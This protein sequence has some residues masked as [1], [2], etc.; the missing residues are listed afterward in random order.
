[1]LYWIIING[2]KTGPLT[3]EETLKQPLRPETLV[4]HQGLA[5]WQQACTIA[6]LA[7]ALSPRECELSPAAQ[8]AS[9]TVAAPVVK[10][11]INKPHSYLAWSIVCLIFFFTI[12]GIV[13]LIYALQVTPAYENGEDEKA[14]KASSIA[15]MWVIVSIS[16]GAMFIPFNFLMIVG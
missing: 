13:A 4:W 3:L 6:S 8:P 16:L 2:Q 15:E 7:P 14:R 1:M 5:S 12:A 11:D 10:T 9:A